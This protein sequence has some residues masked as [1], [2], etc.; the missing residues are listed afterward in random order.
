MSGAEKLKEKIISEA[1]GWADRELAEAG[2]RAGEIVAAARK[3]ADDKNKSILEQALVQAGER[4]RRA[5]TIAELDAR[6]EILRA[7]EELIEDTFRQALERLRLLKGAAA[8]EVLMPML[9]AAVKS[10]REEIIVSAGDREL[11]TPEFVAAVNKA[12]AERGSQ[13]GLILS[14]ETREMRGGFIL[15]SGEVEINSSFDTILRMQRDQLEPEV[16]AALFGG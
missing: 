13:G 9:L 4:R 12:L 8:R 11:F 16:A 15:R 10:G 3:Q 2:L 1:A 7:K 5:A 14:G 6:K